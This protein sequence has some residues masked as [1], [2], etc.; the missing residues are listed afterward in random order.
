MSAHTD[1][2]VTDFWHAT[3]YLAKAADAMHKGKKNAGA[4]VIWLDEARERLKTVK[5]AANRLL[6][7]MKEFSETHKMSKEDR[8]HLK[9]A[10]TYFTNQNKEGRMNYAEQKE[11]NL[12]IGSGITEAAC[13]VIVKQR[14]GGSGM[15]WAKA[16]ASIVLTLR[17]LAYSEGRWNQFWKK[18]EQHGLSLAA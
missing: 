3:E 16:G 6:T 8:D 12:P 11:N 2:Q 10:I 18:V 7:E 5:G 14:L 15:R 13:K 1:I 4:K 17:S 9:N